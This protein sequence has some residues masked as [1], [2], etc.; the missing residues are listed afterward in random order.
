MQVLELIIWCLFAVGSTVEFR[1]YPSV[2]SRHGNIRICKQNDSTYNVFIYPFAKADAHTTALMSLLYIDEINNAIMAHYQQTN[3][4]EI[5]YSSQPRT[6]LEFWHATCKH[7]AEQGPWSDDNSARN[8]SN[9]TVAILNKYHDGITACIKS[10]IECDLTA[11]NDKINKLSHESE[12]GWIVVFK[13]NRYMN[14]EQKWMSSKSPSNLHQLDVSS[15]IIM[16]LHI[17]RK[18]RLMWHNP[19]FSNSKY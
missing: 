2:C 18:Y 3:N 4:A 13:S 6:P 14:Y 8:P 17:S 1:E 11:F 5:E 16:G 12:L 15:Q 7:P 9:L 19:R 10:V